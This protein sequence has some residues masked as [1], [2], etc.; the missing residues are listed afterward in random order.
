ML[1]ACVIIMPEADHVNTSICPG[2]STIRKS[3]ALF[4]L[5]IDFIS[6]RKLAIRQLRIGIAK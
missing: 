1:R 5:S 6:C 3:L 4:L 2:V